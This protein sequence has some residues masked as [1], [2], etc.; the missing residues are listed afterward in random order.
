MNESNKESINFYA[1][2]GNAAANVAGDQSNEQNLQGA[3]SGRDANLIQGDNNS[4]YNI[5]LETYNKFLEERVEKLQSDFIKFERKLKNIISITEAFKGAI[6]E[7]IENLEPEESELKLK[8]FNSLRK[9]FKYLASLQDIEDSS[10]ACQEAA[11]WLLNKRRELVEEAQVFAIGCNFE[12][13]IFPGALASSEKIEQFCKD[14]DMYLLW[15]GHHMAMG[16]TPTPLPEGAIALSLPA[17]IYL[18]VFN[19]ICNQNVCIENGLSKEAVIALR[20]Y[21]SRFVIAPLSQLDSC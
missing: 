12:L 5:R 15:I 9:A 17:W 10:R 19:L 4:V 3:F 20:G 13:K 14:I 6:E 2:V 1:P 7:V 18:E 11:V 21:L 8:L 16:K